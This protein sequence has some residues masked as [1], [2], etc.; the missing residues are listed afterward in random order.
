VISATAR[1]PL[2]AG[3]VDARLLVDI[4]GLASQLPVFVVS[5]GDAAPGAS[6]GTPLRSADLTGTSTVASGNR[7]QVRSM[8]IFLHGQSGYYL[9]ARIQTVRLPG[10]RSGLRVEFA[11]PSPIGL[12]R[13]LLP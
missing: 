11:A 9:P 12:L 7:A 5:F 10:G 6:P 1:R 13:S 3:Q 2:A 4:A 8:S